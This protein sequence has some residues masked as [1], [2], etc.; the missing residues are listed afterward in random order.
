MSSRVPEGEPDVVERADPAVDRLGV[1]VQFQLLGAHRG[2]REVRLARWMRVEPL[3]AQR[4]LGQLAEGALGLGVVAVGGREQPLRDRVVVGEAARF[5][6]LAGVAEQVHEQFALRPLAA[7]HGSAPGGDD[8]H[9]DCCSRVAQRPYPCSVVA[10]SSIRSRGPDETTARPLWW[11][12]S[13]SFSALS[14]G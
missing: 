12:S 11:T 3:V 4:R 13:I 8:P 5:E 6:R 7:Q 10:S 2:G 14:F 9:Q 1:Q